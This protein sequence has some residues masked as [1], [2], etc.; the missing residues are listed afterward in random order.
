MGG[1]ESHCEELLPRIASIDP[2][3]SLEVLGRRPYLP[4]NDCFGGVKVTALPSPQGRSTEAL[5]S[6]V[7][8]ILYAWRSGAR[9]IHIHAIGPGLAA[10][11]ARLLGLRILFTHH[12]EDYRRDKWGRVARLML[13][14]G[15]KFAIWSANTVIAVSPSLADRLKARFPRQRDNILFIPNGAPRFA[16]QPDTDRPLAAFG[17]E[18]K[19]YVLAVARLVPEKG[20]HLLVEAHRLNGDERKLVIVGGADHASTYSSSLLAEA[21]ER[22]M[23]AGIQPRP[24]IAQLYANAGL[25]V[26]P[27]LHEGL[28]IVAL[29]AGI[30]GC[31]MLLSDIQPNLD[32]GLSKEHYFAAGSVANLRAALARPWAS[33]AIDPAH[34]A[35]AFDWDRIAEATRQAYHNVA[36]RPR[37]RS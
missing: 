26:L 21:S 13:R 36:G 7:V 5:V 1:V 16:F 23:F 8:G 19:Q 6:T 35:K 25:F 32:L 29:E 3:V 11:L 27:S 4:S 28:P 30:S 24:I 20:L 12:G 22:I 31:P 2:N 17:L 18:A 9:V 37:D 34:F 15:E 14:I 33:Y 10:P